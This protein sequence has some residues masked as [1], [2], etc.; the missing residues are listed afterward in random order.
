MQWSGISIHILL[1]LETRRF[2][3]NI[4]PFQVVGWLW[5]VER[6]EFQNSARFGSATLDSGMGVR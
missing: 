6:F 1:Q 4:C 3:V 5:V 2:L